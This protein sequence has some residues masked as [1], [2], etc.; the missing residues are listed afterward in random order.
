MAA[1]NIGNLVTGQFAQ[2]Q[3]YAN[4]AQAQ[5]AEFL[6]TLNTAAA[7]AVPTIDVTWSGVE[8]PATVAPPT[9]V[10]LDDVEYT[11]PTP[12]PGELD[13]DLVVLAP[14]TFGESA[15][16]T[17]FP[18]APTL[19]IGTTP[20]IPAVGAVAMPSAPT[21]TMPDAPTL[22]AL[23]IPT[24]GGLDLHEDWL[25][26]LEDIP[27]LSLVEPTPYSYSVGPE[28]AS[29]LLTALQ[30]VITTRLGG[31]D[32]LGQPI[33]GSITTGKTIWRDIKKKFLDLVHFSKNRKV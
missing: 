25:T 9:P 22:L 8:A 31:E 7:Y 28:Y 30:Q 29:A 24:F 19:D 33:V 16:A 14:M 32:D 26:R 17:T 18:T 20:T 21:V 23:N 3:S 12:E 11:A 5:V 4:S 27:T 10:T 15:P 13:I 2:A 6:T 1:T